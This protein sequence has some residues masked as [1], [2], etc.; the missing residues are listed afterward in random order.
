MDDEVVADKAVR[1]RSIPSKEMYEKHVVSRDKTQSDAE[2]D[3]RATQRL[4]EIASEHSDEITKSINPQELLPVLCD[5]CVV[6]DEER[7]LVAREACRKKQRQILFKCFERAP[8]PFLQCLESEEKHCGHKYIVAL[9]REQI[10]DTYLASQVSK[11]RVYEE[12]VLKKKEELIRDVDMT[13]LSREMY[14]Q[15]LITPSEFQALR[16]Q[17]LSKT[18]SNHLFFDDILISKGPLAYLK[19]VWCLE[20]EHEAA[21]HAELYEDIVRCK[22][23]KRKHFFDD[24]SGSESDE[25]AP[26]NHHQ[27]SRLLLKHRAKSQAKDSSPHEPLTGD[28]YDAMMKSLWGFHQ[29]GE[30]ESLD[31]EIDTLVD[32]T[33][34]DPQLKIVALLEKARGYILR[35]NWE[36]VDNCIEEAQRRIELV[37]RHDVVNGAYLLCRLELVLSLQHVLLGDFQSAQ[38][39][40]EKAKA[41]LFDGDIS[42]LSTEYSVWLVYYSCWIQLEEHCQ[43]SEVDVTTESRILS[44]FRAII[45]QEGEC[46]IPSRKWYHDLQDHALLRLAQFYLNCSHFTVGTTRSQENIDQAQELLD[47]VESSS[48]SSPRSQALYHT[49]Q[50]DLS[51]STSAKDEAKLQA[52]RALDISSKCGLMAE[53]DSAELRLK[54]LIQV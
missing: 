34:S 23:T 28:K 12:R 44:D 31:R 21:R 1:R 49:V 38:K 22:P 7:R 3:C 13:Y 35:K 46:K 41:A 42:S 47:S 32:D 14:K 50:S 30:W 24:S 45:D 53:R 11:S 26:G 48:L 25:D 18:K 37:L 29:R 52:Q 27:S 33:D 6:S 40:I 4:L 15:N 9:L 39:H 36:I 2:Q 20:E 54:A 8:Q 17:S 10:S 51:R 16:G 5:M 43:M 19:F